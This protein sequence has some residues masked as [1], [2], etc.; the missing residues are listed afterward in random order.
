[1]AR[2]AWGYVEVRLRVWEG[3]SDPGVAGGTPARVLH[4]LDYR[5]DWT[6]GTGVDQLDRVWSTDELSDTP[7]SLDLVSASSLPS[8]LDTGDNVQFAGGV[9]VLAI[10]NESATDPITI[11][12]GSAGFDGLC[13]FQGT[14]GEGESTIHPRGL[15]LWVAPDGVAPTATTADIL[16]AVF[17]GTG[18]VA[19]K[20]IIAGTSA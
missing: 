6:A 20:L 16:K 5:K 15:L 11:G 9:T 17:S 18:T 14:E 4:S 8:K 3:E 19:C 13:A 1:M 7:S 2:G 10:E 12:G